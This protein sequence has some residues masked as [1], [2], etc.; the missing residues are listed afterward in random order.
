MSTRL[1][2]ALKWLVAIAGT[3][4]GCLAGFGWIGAEFDVQSAIA[5][6]EK[7]LAEWQIIVAGGS[8]A[9][10]FGAWRMLLTFINNNGE[11]KGLL[12]KQDE[13][14]TEE[15]SDIKTSYG[16]VINELKATALSAK[17][18]A[19]TAA[20]QAKAAKKYEQNTAELKEDLRFTAELLSAF[21][22][23]ITKNSTVHNLVTKHKYSRLAQS[24]EAREVT[25]E[26]VLELAEAAVEPVAEVPAEVSA[27]APAE[28]VTADAP[29]PAPYIKV[30]KK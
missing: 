28:A 20:L 8:L 12:L 25:E 7:I 11:L 15:T 3:V 16:N 26:P 1:K 29:E 19:E 21:L 13:K 2:K 30:V 10:L 17:Q 14:H 4:F 9:T 18:A 24:L 6:K 23:S 22:P 27:E 5:I